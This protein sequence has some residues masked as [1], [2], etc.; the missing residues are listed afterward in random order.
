MRKLHVFM[1]L[2]GNLVLQ[3]VEAPEMQDATATTKHAGTTSCRAAAVEKATCEDAA[4][5]NGVL[6][7]LHHFGRATSMA[8]RLQGRTSLL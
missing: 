5:C 3:V 6:R 2:A 1:V 4:L 8:R 7:G